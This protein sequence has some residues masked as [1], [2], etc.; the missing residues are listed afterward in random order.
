M[1]WI[2]LDCG[3]ESSFTGDENVSGSGTRNS[4]FDSEG[5]V[6]DYDDVDWDSIDGEGDFEN[7]ECIECNSHNVEFEDDENRLNEIRIEHNT[8]N[9]TSDYVPPPIVK[10]LSWKEEIEG[11]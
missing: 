9:E 2:C 1:G 10:E 6:N 5:S 7:V 11:K 8:G 3:N 4:Y